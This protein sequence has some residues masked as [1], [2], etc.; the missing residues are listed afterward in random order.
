MQIGGFQTLT[1]SDF[2]GRVASIVFTQGCNFRCPFC[3]NGNL[4]ASDSSE[5]IEEEEVLC[6]LRENNHKL[7]GLVITG[8]EP[9]LQPDLLSFMSEVKSCGLEIKLDTNGSNPAVVEEAIASGLVDYIA[10][11][12]KAPFKKYNLL[13]GRPVSTERIIE[14]IGIITSSG[15]EHE[16]RT[17]AVHQLLSEDDLEAIKR[18]IPEGSRYK[19]Q[20]FKPDNALDPAL[21]R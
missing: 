1:L 16:F 4:L 19:L 10:M 7:D 11:D 20:K 21:V 9:S 6:Y 18:Y 14:S 8:G 17:T 3:H 5:S 15:I 12:V 13:C 2:P